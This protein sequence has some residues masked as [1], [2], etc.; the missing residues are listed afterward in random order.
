MLSILDQNYPN[1]EY[2]VIDGG[3]TDGS[4]DIIKKYEDRLTYWVSEPDNG[5]Y[6]ALQK[7]FEKTTGEI[8]G[9]LNSDDMLHKNT[10]FTVAEVFSLKN[11]KWIQGIP[12]TYDEYGRCVNVSSF[13]SW[14]KFKFWSGDF[15]WIQQ[16][17]I[18]WHRDLWEKAG[19]YISQNYKYAGD[20]ELWN[21]FFQYDKLYSITALVGGYRQR[22]SNQLALEFLSDY[23]KESE[24]ILQSNIFDSFTQET[25]CKINR[26]NKINKKL[27]NINN[28]GG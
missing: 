13:K 15:K 26:I 6:H 28:W 12:T 19:G 3:S 4:I 2:I 14:S 25:L 21:R 16:E 23:L 27:T 17:S 22:S 5:L 8:M 9:W 20:M 18:Y 10:L 11:I 24:H 7:G 1:L